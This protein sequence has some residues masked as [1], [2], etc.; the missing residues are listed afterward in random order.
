MIGGRAAWRLP[1]LPGPPARS[2]SAASW[3]MRMKASPT[4]VI[5]LFGQTLRYVVPIFQRHYVWEEQT[6]WAPL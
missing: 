2:L 4:T 6:Q 3:F 1:E 5:S